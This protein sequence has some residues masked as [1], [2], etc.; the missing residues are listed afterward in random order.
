MNALLNTQHYKIRVKGKLEQTS[1][2]NSALVVEAK[3][4]ILWV[5]HEYGH[6]LYFKIQNISEIIMLSDPSNFAW[7]LKY[8]RL[9][10]SMKF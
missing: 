5:A 7:R 9:R 10:I 8:C 6:Q 2:W 4:E 1:E 3:K